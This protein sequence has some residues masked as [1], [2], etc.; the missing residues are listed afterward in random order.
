L[1]LDIDHLIIET[2]EQS[3]LKRKATYLLVEKLDVEFEFERLFIH[4]FVRLFG[5]GKISAITGT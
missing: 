5:G 4:G 1:K 3:L 2:F